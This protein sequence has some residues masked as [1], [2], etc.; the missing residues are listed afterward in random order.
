MVPEIAFS[1]VPWFKTGL[2]LFDLQSPLVERDFWVSELDTRDRW[3][4][5]PP[6]YADARSLQ[7]LHRLV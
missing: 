5:T 2:D 3:R 1:N 4:A 7:W 6:D